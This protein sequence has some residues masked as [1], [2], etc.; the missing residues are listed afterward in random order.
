MINI[1]IFR[2]FVR[3]Y[4]YFWYNFYKLQFSQMGLFHVTKFNSCRTI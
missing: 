4:L 2:I 1:K 3:V